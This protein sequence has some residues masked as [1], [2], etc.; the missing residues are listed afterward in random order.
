V[1]FLVVGVVFLCWFFCIGW[2]EL[3]RVISCLGKEDYSE[4][5]KKVSRCKPFQSSQEREYA[6]EVSAWLGDLKSRRIVVEVCHDL[7][8]EIR[9]S[10]LLNDLRIEESANAIME[11]VLRPRKDQNAN[12]KLK[13]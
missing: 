5:Y 1:L 3:V 10:A 6:G 12:K 4:R 2:L 9:K 13:L 8:T 7:H 11:S